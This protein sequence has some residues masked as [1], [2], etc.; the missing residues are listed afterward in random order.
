MKDISREKISIIVPIYNIRDLLDEAVQSIVSQ[1][2]ENIEIILV[3]DGSSDGSGTAC[4]SW[5]LRD[6]RIRCI[7]QKNAGAGMARNAGLRLSSGEYV[8]FVDGDDEIAP[9]LCEKLLSELL[10]ERADVSYCGFLN[11]FRDK[12]VEIIP[13]DKMMKG[14]EIPY[15]LVTEISFF[16]AVWN[17]LFKREVLL[18]SE[19]RFIEFSGDISVGED[20]LWLSK[21]LKNAEKAAA[22]PQAL[23]YWKRRENSATQGGAVIRTD[24]AYLTVLKAYREMTLEIDDKPAGKIM[25]KKYL[26]TCRDCMIQAYREKKPELKKALAERIRADKRLYGRADLFTLKLDL[27]VLLAEVNAPLGVIERIQGM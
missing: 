27:C 20:G 23:Y 13:D 4:D 9:D 22:V 10:K 8:L 18:D 11:I 16:T 2:Y 25:C 14:R 5:M 21:V 19:G 12:T 6:S 7:H 1:T 3:D 26:G 17:K 24:D 15:A